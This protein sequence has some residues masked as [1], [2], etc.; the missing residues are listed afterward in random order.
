[1]RDNKKVRENGEAFQDFSKGGGEIFQ[2]FRKIYTPERKIS[3][4]IRDT[5]HRQMYTF[6]HTELS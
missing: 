2:V 4:E 1:M 5:D 6:R 3:N